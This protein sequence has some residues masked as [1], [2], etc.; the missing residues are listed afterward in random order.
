MRDPVDRSG[1]LIALHHQLMSSGCTLTLAALAGLLIGCAPPAPSIGGSDAGSGDGGELPHDGDA[2]DDGGLQLRFMAQPRP[3]ARL[4]GVYEIVLDSARLRLEDLRLIGDASTGQ[5]GT[6]IALD[7]PIAGEEPIVH[8]DDAPP[9]IY[10][11]VLATITNFDLRGTLTLDDDTVDFRIADDTRPI[12]VTIP[13]QDVEVGGPTIRTIDLAVLLDSVVLGIDWAEADE[14]SDEIRID[15]ESP[16]I[17]Q[18][19]SAL[20]RMIDVIGDG[21]GP[22]ATD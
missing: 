17:A 15:D 8:F 19:R 21:G 9:G 18:V 6:E 13:L 20:T 5:V 1:H 2:G 16:E 12:T 4:G 14:S 10:S 22:A 11:N 3:P 7:W